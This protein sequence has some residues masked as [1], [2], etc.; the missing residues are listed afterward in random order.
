MKAPDDFGAFFLYRFNLKIIDKPRRILFD[1][2][3]FGE[4]ARGPK[5][6]FREL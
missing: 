1:E 6:S 5:D 2:V 3:F 4:D